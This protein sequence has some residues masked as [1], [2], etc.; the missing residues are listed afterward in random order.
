MW[1]VCEQ[2]IIHNNNQGHG[3][4]VAAA[5]KERMSG[6]EGRGYKTFDDV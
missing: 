6:G 1:Q 2:V 3:T 4:S 5:E